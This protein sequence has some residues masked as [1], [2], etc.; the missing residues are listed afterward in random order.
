MTLKEFVKMKNISERARLRLE[1]AQ[2]KDYLDISDV[3]LVSGYSISTIMRRIETGHLKALQD[4][5]KGK[6]LFKKDN[7]QKWLEDGAR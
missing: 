2:A 6:L 4:V 7:V 3:A 5:P 1:L